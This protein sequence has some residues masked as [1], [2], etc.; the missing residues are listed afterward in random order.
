MG[1]TTSERSALSTYLQRSLTIALIN[2]VIVLVACPAVVAS[3]NGMSAFTAVA[4]AGQLGGNYNERRTSDNLVKRG[5]EMLDKG[6]LEL[7]AWYLEKAEKLNVDYDGIF[8]RFKDSPAKLR[9]D[10]NQAIAAQ[11][12][13]DGARGPQAGSNRPNRPTT[14]NSNPS[15]PALP[16]QRFEPTPTQAMPNEVTRTQ[17]TPPRAMPSQVTP[18]Q[19]HQPEPR[20]DLPTPN[21]IGAAPPLNPN[22]IDSTR[23]GGTPV[24]EM[25]DNSKSRA[26]RY[27]RQ[28][29]SAL[30]SGNAIAALGYYRAC[31]SCGA[32]FTATDDDTPARLAIDLKR[33]GI[34]DARLVGGNG[35]AGALAGKAQTRPLIPSTSPAPT[36][37]HWQ[38]KRDEVVRK[39]AAASAAIDRGDLK[40]AEKLALEAQ[41]LR[42]PDEAFQPR[43]KRPW[44]VLMDVTRLQNR[45]VSPRNGAT[46]A[47]A[48]STKN[49]RVQLAAG[50]EPIEARPLQG[51]TGTDSLIDSNIIN[52]SPEPQS[53]SEITELVPTEPTLLEPQPLPTTPTTVE[54]ESATAQTELPPQLISPPASAPPVNR[55][56]VNTAQRLFDQGVTALKEHN[57]E[58]AWRLFVEAWQREDE[59]DA[60]TRDR[61]QGYLQS[62][63]A[64]ANEQAVTDN[65]ISVADT[66]DANI[67]ASERE[68]LS[69]FIGEVTREQAAIRRLREQRPTE[70][71]DRL[72]ALRQKVAS[73]EISEGSRNR[74]VDRVDRT[75]MEMES[76]IEENR[77][78]IEL[79]ARNREVLAEVERRRQQR[80]R[81]QEQLADF[82]EQF[83]T[84]MDQQRYPEAEVVA[85]KAREIDSGSPVTQNMMWK[86]QFARQMI[87]HLARNERFSDR[88]G[89]T[90]GSVLDSAVP[91]PDNL[92]Q[93][94]PDAKVWSDMT[95]ARKRFL[96]DNQRRYTEVELEIQQALKKKVD[97]NFNG[98]PLYTVLDSLA[99]MA[100]INV[101]LDPEGIDAHGVT[102]DTP[103]TLPLR[104]PVS[105]RSALNL[106]LEPLELSYVIQDEVLRVTSE[107]VRDGDVYARTYNVADLVIPIPNYAPTYDMGLPGAM[108][109]AHNTAANSLV[110]VTSNAP[111][112]AGGPSPE[113]PVKT[114]D[115]AS[116]LAQLGQSGA[117][118]IIRGRND[119]SNT[120]PLGFGPGGPGGGSQADF[121][122]LIELITTTVEPESWEDLGGSGTLAE[123]PTNLSL[124]VSQTQEVHEKVAD[125]LAQLRRLQDLQ[126]TIEVRFI[127]L[128]DDFFERIGVDFDF[129]V[130]DNT[131][132]S[133]N[134]VA[135]NGIGTQG[136]FDDDGPNVAIGIDPITNLPRVDL[137]LRFDQGSFGQTQPQFGG[138]D[139]SSAA[140]IGFAILSDIEAFFVIQAAQGDTRTNVLQAP[141][142]TLFNGQQAF[143]SDA[144]QRPFVTS[145]I[146]VVGDFAAAHQPVITVLTEGTS[147]SVQAVV[148][149]D[150]RFVR[151]TLV[152]FFSRIGDVDTFQFNGRTDSDSGTTALDPTDEGSVVQE[153]VRTVNE[154]TTVQLPTFAFTTVNTTVSVPDGG[155][156]LLGGIKRL[157]EGRNEQ[158][159]PV[160]SKVP[161]INRLFRNVG[162]GRETT[163]LMMMVTPRIIIQEEEE[164]NVLGGISGS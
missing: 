106:I 155:T 148:S 112:L 93:E 132:L 69:R 2:G 142:V 102:P 62:F 125:L 23:I 122:T 3:P 90:I 16:S 116:A 147:L 15:V 154:G 156:I 51:T 153:N 21:A 134:E 67:S 26:V 61:L 73:A 59:L 48:P 76:Y 18:I 145:V 105:L 13:A 117:L 47:E 140:N 57:T 5:R 70:A 36:S 121:E 60:A 87:T 40:T 130:D 135:R 50:Q 127:T 68:L 143:I 37:G 49:T 131:G 17:A 79:D 39:L 35:N 162:I 114:P 1:K 74:L 9:N 98:D 84:L 53:K 107:L 133:A 45:I 12:R 14:T 24:T 96:Q 119:A 81:D 44:M 150:R 31:L 19:P 159:V 136:N 6:N 128:N 25:T 109:E 85:R 163:S 144:S 38:Q 42:V 151:L 95:A 78:M 80:V 10:L 27:L 120:N 52:Q 41:D 146:P 58:R 89:Q 28:A 149:N 72:K 129:E 157:S 139:V 160:L 123:F 20:L 65:E 101:F 83:N 108:R 126:V 138:F 4:I 30:N 29:R 88:A 100:G 63:A 124:V 43:D 66:A 22:T 75:L 115:S 11:Q 56:P 141:K 92:V 8:N 82:V 113:D 94:F 164:A 99:K 77:A 97:V 71:W 34:E 55:P 86:V 152:P 33:A 158:G 46:P 7:A 118:D 110:G 91:F 64:A 103:I 161:Y 54:S 137:D 111:F 32:A 104:K